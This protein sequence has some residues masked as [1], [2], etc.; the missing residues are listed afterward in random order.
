MKITIITFGIIII[1]ALVFFFVFSNSINWESTKGRI[2]R[3]EIEEIY[4]HME[5]NREGRG[6][7][8][9]KIH[10]EYSYTL[11]N[12][13]HTGNQLIAGLPNIISD[14]SIATE[15]LEKYPVG[16]VVDVWYNPKNM[17]VSALETVKTN[18]GIKTIVI[19]AIFFIITAAFVGGGFYFMQ[20]K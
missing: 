18:G 2:N 9:Y 6:M 10:L 20:K 16:S 15:F 14:K 1:I 11:D 8:D 12:Q 3:I 13:K 4:H 19:F 17:N 5:T 7:I